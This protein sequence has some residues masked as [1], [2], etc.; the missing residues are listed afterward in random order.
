MHGSGL[1]RALTWETTRV[2]CIVNV[3][4]FS[5]LSIINVYWWLKLNYLTKLVDHKTSV[6]WEKST[7]TRDTFQFLFFVQLNLI[8]NLSELKRWLH[9]I[10]PK[11]IRVTSSSLDHWER[12]KNMFWLEKILDSEPKGPKFS[13]NMHFHTKI[14]VYLTR[15]N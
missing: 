13:L 1:I 7:T 12:T 2:F 14:R 4:F 9:Q 11:R 5:F 15:S 10:S 8:K 3:F 6:I